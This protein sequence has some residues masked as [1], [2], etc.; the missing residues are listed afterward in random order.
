M[1]G[2]G[3]RV[4]DSTRPSSLFAQAEVLGYRF[5]Y[6]G[7]IIVVQSVQK[8]VESCSSLEEEKYCA[9]VGNVPPR[10]FVL[11]S[12][13]GKNQKKLGGTELVGNSQ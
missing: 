12:L 9:Q 11:H 8:R 1:A 10:D 4:R 3:R 6:G 2:V 13:R 7:R 5:E